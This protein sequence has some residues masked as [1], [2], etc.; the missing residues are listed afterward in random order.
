M[1][2]PDPF[3]PGTDR[4]IFEGK[5]YMVMDCVPHL[6]SWRYVGAPTDL[7]GPI[8]HFD[9]EH[10]VL[11]RP[12]TQQAPTVRDVFAAAALDPAEFDRQEQAAMDADEAEHPRSP[13]TELLATVRRLAHG[14]D[15][16]PV[17]HAAWLTYSEAH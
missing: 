13:L 5:K 14:P 11:V 15:P 12:T 8:V 6:D 2:A 17:L 4:V 7:A 1:T 16:D 3:T 10:A 9:H